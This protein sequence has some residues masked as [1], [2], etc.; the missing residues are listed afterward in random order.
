MRANAQSGAK[1]ARMISNL[2]GLDEFT[3]AHAATI[4]IRRPMVDVLTASAALDLRHNE[5]IALVESGKLCWAWNIASPNS[6][7]RTIRILSRS[8]EEYQTGKGARYANAQEEFQAVIRLI[9]PGLITQPGV[10]SLVRTCDL[11][12]RFMINGGTMTRLVKAGEFEVGRKAT[13]ARGRTGSPAL[14]ASSV[15]EFLARRRIA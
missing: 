14:K 6:R 13:A 10:V 2:D 5:V 9:H 1:E 7:A 8:L 4:R 12:Q 15:V 11:A 3:D